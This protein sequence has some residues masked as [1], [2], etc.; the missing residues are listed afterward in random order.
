MNELEKENIRALK[1]MENE[2]IKD[3]LNEDELR[4]IIFSNNDEVRKQFRDAFTSEIEDVI[5]YIFISYE[6]YKKLEN[7]FKKQARESYIAA[8]LFNSIHSLIDS[9]SLLISGFFIPSGNLVRQ[10]IESL[11]MAILIS[12]KKLDYFDKFEKDPS[13]FQTNQSLSLI[14]T[15]QNVF[16]INKEGW[17]A[18]KKI[19]N[20]HHMHSHPSG[21]SLYSFMRKTNIGWVVKFG[22][23]Y[24]P[25]KKEIYLK[26]IQGC[27]TIAKYIKNIV[28]GIEKGIL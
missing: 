24:D 12:N 27:I 11:A 20:F 13:K 7:K 19:R 15:N 28:E 22:A 9:V 25:D 23:D 17:A 10:S 26:E 16:N 14:E 3:K 2:E 5:K 4:D 21:L 6:A 1:N 8:F 18:F